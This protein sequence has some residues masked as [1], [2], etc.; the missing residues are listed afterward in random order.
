MEIKRDFYLNK[1]LSKKHSGF[2][3]VITGIR[4]CGKSYLLNEIFCNKLIDEGVDENQII[5]FAFDSVDSLELIDESPIVLA[6]EKRLVD[7]K[8]FIDYIASKLNP[9]KMN[10]IL[11]DEIQLLDCFESVL[12]SYL[13]MNNVDVYVTGS[14]AKLLAKDIITEF[15]GRG[16][17]IR[18]YPLSLKEYMQTTDSDKYQALSEYMLYGGIPLVVLEED[19]N[20]KAKILKSL[21]SEIYLRDIYLRYKIKNESE[22]DDLLNML[23]SSIGSLTN[24][25]KL[26]NTF[27]TVMGS[28]ITANTIR[29]YIEYLEDSFMISSANRYDIKGKSYISTPKK[30]YFSDLGLRNSRINFRQF[31]ETHSMENV[32]FN[33]LCMRGYNVDVGVVP[34]VDRQESTIKKKQLEIDFVC[35]LGSKRYYIQS[36]YSI[37][38]MDKYVAETRGLRKID[39]SFKKIIITHDLTP[40]HYDENGILHLNIYD[41]LLKDNALEF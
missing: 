19:K 10:Y 31:E 9:D 37:P 25:Q 38:D 12:N 21:F 15:A 7:P 20:E 23:S 17:E 4:R 22:M 40:E 2:I 35:N 5:K 34:F 30:Y 36:S 1:L 41:F 18:M 11:L 29:N 13:R 3:K 8:K 28:N 24:P 27:S 33:E 14:N 6:K 16:D 26:K 32:I 39:D